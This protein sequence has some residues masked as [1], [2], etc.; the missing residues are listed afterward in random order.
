V[1]YGGE[2]IR[3]AQRIADICVM[4]RQGLVEGG[5]PNRTREFADLVVK[6]KGTEYQQMHPAKMT[7]Q[8]LRIHINREFDELKRG[9]A[10]AL[11]VL[12]PGG[13][14]G[15]ITWKHS[16]CAIVVDYH[17]A[18]EVSRPEYPML[19]WYNAAYKGVNTGDLSMLSEEIQEEEKQ[20]KTPRKKGKPLLN[21]LPKNWGYGALFLQEFTLEDAIGSHACLL[22]ANTHVTNG[23]PLGSSIL[24]PVDTVNCVATLKVQHGRSI[25]TYRRRVE[26]ELAIP[27]RRAARTA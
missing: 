19:Q 14:L 16:E 6:A 4:A 24:L 2:N 5:L 9:M 25:T 11:Q 18:G 8:A 1:D 21:K 3:A 12:L 17:R 20:R 13:K 23:I 15:I 26:I 27:V 22:E 7:F 10:S